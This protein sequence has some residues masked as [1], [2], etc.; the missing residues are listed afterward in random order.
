MAE[1]KATLRERTHYKV[2][3]YLAK[4]SSALFLSLLIAFLI[5]FALIAILRLLLYWFSPD[6][7]AG[8]T[9]QLW[10]VYL[11]LTAPGNMNQDSK[12]PHH[13][14]IAA[15][16][17]GITGVVIFSTLIATLTTAL[18]QAIRSLKRGHSRVLE[19]DHTLILG[20]THRVPEIL[21]EL[22]EANESEDDP[23]VVILSEKDKEWMDEYLRNHFK[24]RSNLRI[25][26]RSGTPASPKSLS[27]VSV[28]FAKSVIVLAN[29]NENSDLECQ[30]RSDARGIKTMLAIEAAAPEAEFPIVIEL[31]HPRN[32]EV[33]NAVAPG[34]VFMVDAEEILAKVMV[35]TS[36]TTGL[37]VVYSELL[38]F[39]GCEMYFH[40][41]DWNG[42]S[43]GE[44]Q[45]HFP[46]GV[47]IGI[48]KQSGEVKLRPAIDYTMEAEDE[49]LIVAEDDSTIEF[50]DTPV[51]KPQERE[52][53][54]WRLEPKQE[55][56]LLMGWSPKAHIIIEEYAEHVADG[57]R[58][59]IALH[60]PSDRIIEEVQA[61][62]G[63]N[64]GLEINLIQTNPFDV[65]EVKKLAPFEYDDIMI[66]P[67]KLGP[68]KDAET[69]DTETIVLLLLLRGLKKKLIDQGQK[70]TTKIV[71]EVLDSNN[72]SL[73]YQAGVNDFI[74][75]NRM[76]SMIFA[77][78][79]EEP[80]IKLVYDDLFQEEGSEIYVK[81]AE[82]YFESFPVKAT[83]AD[84]MSLAQKRDEEACIGIK[85]AANAPFADKNYGV[86][87][88]PPK[89]QV[90]ELNAGDALVV[91]AEDER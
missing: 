75:S 9:D 20:W 34:R 4:G 73:I 24:E 59:T 42:I 32:R 82:L 13:F 48:R 19:N 21:R 18:N 54:H 44:C 85:F 50:L 7:N 2:D 5:S 83:F 52:L 57:S 33:V 14:K 78:M 68:D 25:V 47:P 77:Q 27:H 10:K 53:K 88:I 49:V 67:Q 89:D 22:V 56:L 76:V 66:L 37:S 81:P 79:S 38:S 28:Q 61:T 84:L 63:E 36:R 31:Y 87:L 15:I 70:V 55:R 12:S 46:D 39:D 45:F 90:I 11:Q 60:E 62:V 91:V 51:A 35:Q 16:L 69:I 72:H 86:D 43:F 8:F 17:A 41:A 40:N 30:I 6:P 74:I 64:E 1:H 3:N 71:T 23:C 80:G 58:I 65:E 29:C 26:T